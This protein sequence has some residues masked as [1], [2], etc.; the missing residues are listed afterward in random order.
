MKTFDEF[1]SEWRRGPGGSKVRIE[2]VVTKGKGKKK[3]EVQVKDVTAKGGAQ[4]KAIK[5]LQADKAKR[6]ESETTAAD[7]VTGKYAT[8]KDKKAAQQRRIARGKAQ[9][10]K[11]KEASKTKPYDDYSTPAAHE[12]PPRAVKRKLNTGV[13]PRSRTVD[14]RS[15]RDAD[16]AGEG[17]R[18]KRIY[19]KGGANV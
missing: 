18:M 1:I 10:E 15:Q 17:I 5:K 13:Y 8:L 9:F 16:S 11:E 6:K 19:G 3:Q 2:P 7:Q 12:N 4:K 14:N